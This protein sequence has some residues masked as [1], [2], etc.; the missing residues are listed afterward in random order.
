MA[1]S[2]HDWHMTEKPMH[3]GGPVNLAELER[4]ALAASPGPWSSWIEGRDH[5]SGD[6]FIETAAEDLYPHVVISGREFNPNWHADQDFIA[7]ANPV[8]ILELLRM[9]RSVQAEG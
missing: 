2:V 7:A 5:S 6:S 8:T 9:V 1:R 3:R 4:L